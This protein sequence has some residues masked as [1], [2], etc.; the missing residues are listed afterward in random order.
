MKL[1]TIVIMRVVLLLLNSTAQVVGYTVYTGS[2]E[3]RLDGG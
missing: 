2:Q 1:G 3:T